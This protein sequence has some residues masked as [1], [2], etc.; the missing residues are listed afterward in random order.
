MNSTREGEAHRCSNCGDTVGAAQ[1]R[2]RDFQT[3]MAEE[4]YCPNC[5]Q[6][7]HFGVI[8]SE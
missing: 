5:R 6:Q 1:N 3:E 4:I 8:Q 2:I 7:K